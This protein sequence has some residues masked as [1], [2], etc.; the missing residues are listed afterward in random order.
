MKISIEPLH[1]KAQTASEIKRLID[2]YYSDLYTINSRG[3]SVAS[4]SLVDFFN[5]VKQIPY[6]KDTSPV[7]V[8]GRPKIIAGMIQNGIDCKKKSVLCGSYAKC[9]AIDFRAVGS[10][11]RKD[12][13]IHHIYIEIKIKGKYV[14]YDATYDFYKPFENKSGLTNKEVFFYG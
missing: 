12:K 14:P 2:N 5:L 13:R 7:E 11:K 9:N 1:D 8:I 6:K 10:S 4:L 3:S